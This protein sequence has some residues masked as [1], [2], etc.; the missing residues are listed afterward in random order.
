MVNR[1]SRMNPRKKN[2]FYANIFKKTVT[3]KCFEFSKF[4][5]CFVFTKIYFCK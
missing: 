4:K 3:A 2:M 1:N 5:I